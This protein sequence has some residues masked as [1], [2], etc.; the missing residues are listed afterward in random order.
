MPYIS[1]TK[2]WS[3]EAPRF[4]E[5]PLFARLVVGR[6][7]RAAPV[8]ARS[9]VFVPGAECRFD[10]RDDQLDLASRRRQLG[11]SGKEERLGNVQRQGPVEGPER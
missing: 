11:G 5:R 1:F 10:F 6:V 3:S 7:R 2:P 4:A 9:N 8:T